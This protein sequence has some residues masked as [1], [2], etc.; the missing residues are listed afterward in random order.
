[1]NINN[2]YFSGYIK[3]FTR[4]PSFP[5]NI[6]AFKYYNFFKIFVVF[7]LFFV[8]I[9]TGIV[10]YKTTFERDVFYQRASAQWQHRGI[11]KKTFQMMHSFIWQGTSS[12][13]NIRQITEKNIQRE[14]FWQNVKLIVFFVLFWLAFDWHRAKQVLFAIVSFGIG[15]A[16]ALFPIDIIPDFIPVI[17]FLDDILVNIFGSTIG[18]S[19]LIEQYKQHKNNKLIKDLMQKDPSLAVNLILE[20]H[21]YLSEKIDNKSKNLPSNNLLS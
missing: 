6:F 17:G 18:I 14:R 20:E 9:N 2:N 7:C 4:E 13:E 8:I 12:E 15:I 16:Y 19:A 3:E 1:M 21:G 11:V 10:Y 5:K